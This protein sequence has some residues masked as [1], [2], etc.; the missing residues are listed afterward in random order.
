MYLYIHIYRCIYIY[1]LWLTPP[2]NN[3]FSRFSEPRVAQFEIKHLW[4]KHSQM[5]YVSLRLTRILGLRTSFNLFIKKDVE[6]DRK[7]QFIQESRSFPTYVQESRSFPKYVLATRTKLFLVKDSNSLS[8]TQR[9]HAPKQALYPILFHERIHES[10]NGA[11]E[12]DLP[13][14]N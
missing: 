12:Q 7:V 1:T 6:V 8:P 4:P 14:F 10:P 5:L 9:R 3:Y 11:F 2:K 13:D